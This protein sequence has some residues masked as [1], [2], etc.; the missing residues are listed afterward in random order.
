MNNITFSPTCQ[1]GIEH[2]LAKTAKKKMYNKL[3][4]SLLEKWHEPDR[5]RKIKECAT[6]LGF[7]DVNGVAKIV[8]ADFCRQRLC[9]VCAWRR[10]AKFQAQTQPI[11]QALSGKYD[12]IF[13]TLTIKNCGAENLKTAFDEM[14]NAWAK[15]SKKR[16]IKRSFRGIIRSF[17][18][19]FNPDTADF[20][21]HIHALIAVDKDYFTN[22]EKYL[23]TSE[24][25]E[26]WR[27]ALEVEYSPICY[28]ETIEDAQRG[29]LE[30]LKYSLKPTLA[31]QA[32]SAFHH[33]LK[34][35]RLISFSGVFAKARK[36][37]NLSDF[38]TILTDDIDGQIVKFFNVYKFD[39]T[40]GLYKFYKTFNF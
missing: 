20:H 22:D 3:P 24:I 34:G 30:T 11:L 1:V 7:A 16:K 37:A 13:L 23:T 31:E 18:I 32:L 39:P 28:V 8:S 33:L 17:E 21:P 25:V 10:S 29:A 38:N 35:R 40:G 6:H 36:V 27:S 2:I 4:I 15:F 5:A 19:T 26:Y 14:M 12:Y 9:Q